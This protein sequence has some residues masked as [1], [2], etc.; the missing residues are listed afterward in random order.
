MGN[1]IHYYPKAKIAHFE[2]NSY[3]LKV[4]DKI[5]IIGPTTGVIETEITELMVDSKAVT[6]ATRGMTCTFPLQE[7]MRSSDK[8]YKFVAAEAE[9]EA[10]TT[11]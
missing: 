2:I 11:V 6:E 10:E 8:L 3:S 4:G 1:G 7:V 9:A 5:A